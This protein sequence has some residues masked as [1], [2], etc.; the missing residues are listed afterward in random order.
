MSH[1]TWNIADI[2]IVAGRQRMTARVVHVAMLWGL[3][4]G[5]VVVASLI[6]FGV[7][8]AA[9]TG[10]LG[11][12]PGPGA[13]ALLAGIATGSGAVASVLWKRISTNRRK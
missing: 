13:P 11:G 2:E 1:G 4:F 12:M 10:R 9:P 8:E 5:L 7:A 3:A 6:G